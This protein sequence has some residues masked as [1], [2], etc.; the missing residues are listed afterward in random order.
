[1]VKKISY[2]GLSFQIEKKR[3]HRQIVNS[4]SNTINLILGY[5]STILKWYLVN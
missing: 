4:L 1:M 2:N 3:K 5:I